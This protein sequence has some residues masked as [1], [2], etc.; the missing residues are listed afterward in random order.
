MSYV[1]QYGVW[2]GP[3]RGVSPNIGLGG[4]VADGSFGFLENVH[5]GKDSFSYNNDTP[6][7]QKRHL[8]KCI[9]RVPSYEWSRRLS[10]DFNKKLKGICFTLYM[11]QLI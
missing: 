2:S 8:N 11:I 6:D 5:I 10:Q 3:S 7:S 4:G 9:L 1:S